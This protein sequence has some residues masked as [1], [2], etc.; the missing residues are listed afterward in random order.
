MESGRNGGIG[1]TGRFQFDHRQRHNTLG[2]G[3]RQQH[4]VFPCTGAGS[5]RDDGELLGKQGLPGL[6]IADLGQWKGILG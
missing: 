5:E 3:K 2:V 6:R 4:V 1:D